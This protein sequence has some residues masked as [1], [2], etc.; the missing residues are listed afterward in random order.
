MRIKN[1]TFFRLHKKKLIINK[2]KKV[3]NKI[4]PISKQTNQLMRKLIFRIKIYNLQVIM[5]PKKALILK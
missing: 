2:T 5:F 1:S 3:N 4:K